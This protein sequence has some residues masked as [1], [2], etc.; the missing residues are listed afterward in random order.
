MD[1]IRAAAHGPFKQTAVKN[2]DGTFTLLLEDDVFEAVTTLALP[3][4]SHD[5]TIFRALNVLRGKRQ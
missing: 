5:D 1:A 2:A 4:E 3:G